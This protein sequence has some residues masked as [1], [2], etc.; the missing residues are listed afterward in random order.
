MYRPVTLETWA[1]G[2]VRATIAAMRN[3]RWH[4][5]ILDHHADQVRVDLSA[6]GAPA[7][8]A[9]LTVY[10]HVLSQAVDYVTTGVPDDALRLPA[11]HDTDLDWFTIRIAAVCQV[12]I[13]EGLIA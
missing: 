1:S 13:D 4:A 12:A 2:P 3:D 7:D 11:V 9:T 5:A 8:R 10:L 6:S